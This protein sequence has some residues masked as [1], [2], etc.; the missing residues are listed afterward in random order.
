LVV[1]FLE[2]LYHY[3]FLPWVIIF[4]SNYLLRN[5]RSLLLLFWQVLLSLAAL[6]YLEK[7]FLA[8]KF[9]ARNWNNCGGDCSWNDFGN[10]LLY[11][12]L[13]NWGAALISL[14]TA[15]VLIRRSFRSS[16]PWDRFYD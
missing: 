13:R 4:I 11:T 1:N 9:L 2:W 12:G 8:A 16:D 3:C 5:E 14:L 15:A 6:L 7:S 10:D